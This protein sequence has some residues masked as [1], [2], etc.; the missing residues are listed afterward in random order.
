MT[1]LAVGLTIGRFIIHWR[2]SRKIR[3]DDVF[4]A[5]AAFFLLAYT[6]TY[7]LYVPANY[8]AQLY[9]IG[10]TDKPPPG[11]DPVRNMKYT[12]AKVLL[13]WLVIYAVKASFLAL[14]WQIFHLSR[15]FRIAW[16]VLTV[17]TAL[18]FVATWL[19]DFWRCGSPKDFMNLRTCRTTRNSRSYNIPGLTCLERCA[20][21]S[22]SLG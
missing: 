14:Y 1:A 2:K 10:T 11:H 5:A 16:T 15:R 12:R 7:Q 20:K 13:F 22:Q 18:S 21:M 3:C 8:E 9:G 19:S 6:I 4:N 17:Y